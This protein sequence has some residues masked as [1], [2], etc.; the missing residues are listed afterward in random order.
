MRC[1][2]RATQA[3]VS[4]VGSSRI[5]N[6]WSVTSY[7]RGYYNLSTNWHLVGN[8]GNRFNRNYIE[9]LDLRSSGPPITPGGVMAALSPGFN[10]FAGLEWIT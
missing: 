4:A 8:I 6:G 7:P 5:A 1:K 2:A 10:P 3:D 9:H